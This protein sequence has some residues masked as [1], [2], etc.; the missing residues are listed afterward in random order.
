MAEYEEKRRFDETP[1]PEGAGAE[2]DVDPLTAP[3]GDSFVIQQHYA[4]RLHHDVRLEMLN[5]D[6]PVLVSWAVPKGLPRQRGE[7]HLAIRTEDHPFEYGT[8][9]GTIPEGNYGAGEVRIFDHGTYE[10]VG[11]TDDRLTFR[12]DGDRLAGTYHLIKTGMED[13]REQWLALLSEDHRPEPDEKPPLRPML[14]TLA[15]RAFD[16]SAWSF[17]PKWD[18]IRALA[19]CD[20]ETTL[21]S[22][23]G[24]R[25]TAGY[26]ELQALHD[27]LVAVDAILDG[28]IVAF[29]DGRPS[30]QRL[31]GRMHVRDSRRLEQLVRSTPVVFMAFDLL[32]LDGVDLTGE[33]FTERRRRLE[34]T[35]VASDHL[36]LSP[37]VAGSGEALYEAARDQ[38]LEGII[39][40]RNSSVYETGKRSRSW[41]KIK[42][43]LDADVVIVGWS[44]GEGRR[45]G[46]IG[47]L[48]MAVYEGHRLRYVGNVGT[49]FDRAGLEDAAERLSALATSDA[50]FDAKTIRS[51]RELRGAHWAE[52]SLV[53]HIEHRE[54]TAA[55]KLRAPAFKGFRDDKDPRECTFDQL[56]PAEL[57]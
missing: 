5:G 11:R 13:D 21:V 56:T 34:E 25:V 44:E 22:R 30:F 39:A 20:V 42:V 28:E 2:A 3:T 32:Y 7:R 46:G 52:P 48:V 4:T 41:L 14:A 29:E 51:N 24:N 43:I 31:Q 50:P 38:S 36:Q 54:L 53:A 18:G 26:P 23:N 57:P 37:V 55:G 15:E 45:S 27:R 6:T 33:P 19:M 49:G 8:F 12:L 35:V 40:K 9:E 17:E 16:N 47:S 1:E 10:T